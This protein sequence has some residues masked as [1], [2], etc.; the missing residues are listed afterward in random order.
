LKFKVAQEHKDSALKALADLGV[1]EF[2]LK[3]LRDVSV[4]SEGNELPSV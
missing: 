2:T 4:L 1:L 3:N